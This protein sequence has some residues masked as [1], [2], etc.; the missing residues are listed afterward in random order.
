METYTWD[1]HD[2]EKHAHAQ[3]TWARELLAKIKLVGI[4]HILD[5]G[6]GDESITAELANRVPYGRVVGI[7][8]SSSMVTFAKNHYST[9]THPNLSFLE[10]D[11][12]QLSFYEEFDVAFSYAVLHWVKDHRPVIEGV[13]RSLKPNGRV[14]LQMGGQGNAKNVISALQTIQKTQRWVQYF[15]DFEVPYGFHGPQ[16]Y[17]QWLKEAS[18]TPERVELISKDMEHEGEPGLAGWIRTTWLPF[19]ERVPKEQ[20]DEFINELVKEYVGQFPLDANGKAHVAM[21]RLEVVATKIL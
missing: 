1:A 4:E 17:A 10:M 7:D 11:A 16:E 5:I 8:S 14:L 12:M 18:L 13:Y 3:K 19:T 20:R 21:I 6:C 15:S 2:Y 9:D